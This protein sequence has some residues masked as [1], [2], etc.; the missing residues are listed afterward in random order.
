[1]NWAQSLTIHTLQLNPQMSRGVIQLT[2]HLFW[3]HSTPLW[4]TH[5]LP[6]LTH[7]LPVLNTFSGTTHYPLALLNTFFGTTQHPSW[8]HST[9]VQRNTQYPIVN[10]RPPTCPQIVYKPLPTSRFFR[11]SGVWGRLTSR[12][13]SHQSWVAREIYH[14]ILLY[15]ILCILFVHYFLTSFFIVLFSTVY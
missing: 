9:P 4:L 5:H 12:N 6:A 11:Q 13:R 2:Q 15:I 3:H 14:S 7:H 10:E 8:H 1:M